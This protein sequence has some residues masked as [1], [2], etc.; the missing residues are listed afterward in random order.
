MP[1]VNNL[2]QYGNAVVSGNAV[3]N[4]RVIGFVDFR[5]ELIWVT[6]KKFVCILNL[7]TLLLSE[8]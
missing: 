8:F 5:S 1:S 6:P 2:I 3:L 4:L 7:S